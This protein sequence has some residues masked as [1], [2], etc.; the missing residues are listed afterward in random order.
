MR[1]NTAGVSTVK[2]LRRGQNQE[3][4]AKT[5]EGR[6]RLDKLGVTGSSPVP[7]M[8]NACKSMFSVFCREDAVVAVLTADSLARLDRAWFHAI[9]ARRC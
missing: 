3:T 1:A 9:P 2:R 6:G 4:A 7:P 8:E 5:R